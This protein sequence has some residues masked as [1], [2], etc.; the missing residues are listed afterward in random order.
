MKVYRPLRTN[1][2]TQDFGA[3]VVCEYDNN[4]GIFTSKNIITGLCPTGTTCLYKRMGMLGHNGLDYGAYKGEP[5]YFPLDID[6]DWYAK[7]EIDSAGGI[8]VDVIGR[9]P[10]KLN[11]EMRYIKFR[12]WHFNKVNVYD[13][14][15]INFCQQ[16]GE[17]GNTGL[18]TG[19]HLHWSMKYVDGNGK[20][21]NLGNGY[22]GAVDFAEYYDN[23]LCLDIAEIKPLL[24]ERVKNLTLQ[25]LHLAT[26]LLNRLMGKV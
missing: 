19:V 24:T 16:I 15:K 22:Y 10:V 26:T 3:C 4:H 6:L 11:G 9:K 20:S 8:G 21:M 2:K 14:Q 1:I 12:F 23:T 5:V 18:G 7:T 17:A 25:T 13:G